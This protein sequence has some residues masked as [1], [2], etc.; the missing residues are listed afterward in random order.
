MHLKN[1]VTPDHVYIFSGAMNSNVNYR[2]NTMLPEEIYPGD[3]YIIKQLYFL[4]KYGNSVFI[5]HFIL[6]TRFF[7]ENLPK[8]KY[9]QL[10]SQNIKITFAAALLKLYF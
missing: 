6:N 1:S 9:R 7:H 8:K 5:P 2:I 4:K 10:H 3:R